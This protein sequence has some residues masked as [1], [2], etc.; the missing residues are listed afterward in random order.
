MLNPIDLAP[1]TL[2]RKALRQQLF[3]SLPGCAVP[4]PFKDKPGI[5]TMTN[6]VAK[7]SQKMGSTVLIDGDVIDIGE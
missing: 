5:E 4:E 1:K 2:T 6:D 3:N 7:L